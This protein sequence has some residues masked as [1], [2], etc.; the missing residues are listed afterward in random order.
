MQGADVGHAA[1]SQFGLA[2]WQTIDMPQTYWLDLS[3]R[4]SQQ[5]SADHLVLELREDERGLDDVA[6]RGR[7]DRDALQ[8]APPLRL[9]REAAFSLVAQG[10]QQRVAGF[11]VNIQFAAG[12]LFAGTSTP[13]PAPS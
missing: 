4:F 3:L 6:D 12:R 11:R 2:R 1:F 5:L 9:Q 7:A 10:A 8:D 13:A